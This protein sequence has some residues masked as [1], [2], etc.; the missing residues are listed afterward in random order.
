M[1]SR[2]VRPDTRQ[3]NASGSVWR[4]RAVAEALVAGLSVDAVAADLDPPAKTHTVAAERRNGP[5]MMVGD[6]VT[7]AP[8]LAA[9]DLGVALGA[10]GAAAA[11]EAA[12][13]VLIVDSLASLPEA[14]RIARRAG[15]IALQ[16]VWAGIGLSLAAMVAAALGY[17]PPLQGALLQEAIDDAVV[18]NAMRVLGG[19]R[20]GRAPAAQ[21]AMRHP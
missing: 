21:A 4:A 15:A 7:D 9:A 11:A 2:P 3:P 17:L 14:I 5:V 8:A 12:D 20:N 13:V 18:L 6:R 16:G 10:R 1:P 19:P